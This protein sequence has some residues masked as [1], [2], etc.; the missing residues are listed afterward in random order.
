MLLFLTTI[1]NKELIFVAAW[2]YDN[3]IRINLAL[4]QTFY[5]LLNQQRITLPL[6]LTAVN[7]KNLTL[8]V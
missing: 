3:G 7:E 8:N 4:K 6:L 1:L 5:Y 2:F